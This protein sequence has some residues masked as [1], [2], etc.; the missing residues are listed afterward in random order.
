MRRHGMVF[1][2]VGKRHDTAHVRPSLAGRRGFEG[3]QHT[4]RFDVVRSPA[5]VC[6]LRWRLRELCTDEWTGLA[7]M[8]VTVPLSVH[9]RAVSAAVCGVGRALGWR[10]GKRRRAF[11]PPTHVEGPNGSRAA[12][13]AA[14]RCL[15]ALGPAPPDATP[16]SFVPL[17]L[18]LFVSAICAV[19]RRSCH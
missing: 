4:V 16:L 12:A 10:F 1:V 19:L 18:D 11:N 2:I 9:E 6:M 17:R 5:C 7:M 15:A 14:V 3:A 13:L 8:R